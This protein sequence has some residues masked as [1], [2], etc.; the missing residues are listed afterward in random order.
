MKDNR[1]IVGLDIGTTKISTVIGELGPDGVLD[2]IGEGT[3][4]SE[5]MKKG[6]VVNLERTTAA[7]RQSV[8]AAE[9]VAGVKV[10]EAYVGV[11]GAHIRALTSHGLAAIRR[12]QEITR[13]DVER[14]IENAKAVP[15]DP[16]IEVIHSLP[17][18]YVIDGQEGIKNPVGMQGVRLEVD[19]H[20][21]TGASGPLANLRRCISEAGLGTKQLV[22]Q[23][24]ASGLAV[25]DAS[26]TE[27]TVVLID[28]GGGTTDVGVFRR[29]NLAHS[30][31]IPIG[32]DHITADLAQILKIP[33]EEAERIKR[34][35]GSALP[36]LADPDLSLEITQGGSVTS[37]SA[38]ELSRIIKPR[39]AEIYSLVRDQI[40]AAL[41]PIE[42]V[43]SSV[44]LT[45]GASL[46]RGTAELARDRFRLPVRLGRP[47][48]IEGLTDVVSSPAHATAVGLARYG[49]VYDHE[50][51]PLATRSPEPR[52]VPVPNVPFSTPEATPTP[53]VRDGRTEPRGDTRPTAPVTPPAAEPPQ[54]AA[55]SN[56][57]G[58][59]F[60][61]RVREFFKDWF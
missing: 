58:K 6:A 19:V 43:A 34:K 49:A 26:E 7:I 47:R 36:D 53:V 24:Y 4:P 17:Q 9:R 5:G 33:L 39:V 18:E 22:L 21:V 11:A 27:S 14:A 25:L 10:H 59:G 52:T 28:I 38:F 13:A 23:A 12:N 44:I 35:Y 55:A 40:D 41:G 56:G 3:V 48:G 15:M 51:G 60:M 54:K 29:G 42:L 37:I 31:V 30:A 50:G 2:V 1:I 61:D 32:G 57:T 45:G 16:N 46:M 20:I 8:A